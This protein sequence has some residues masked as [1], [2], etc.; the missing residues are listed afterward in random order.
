V[1]AGMRLVS[2]RRRNVV[3]AVAG[4]TPKVAVSDR[5]LSVKPGSGA[6]VAADP[7]LVAPGWTLY[8]L[9]ADE[10]EFWQGDPE[11]RHVRLRYRRGADGWTR[12]L[13]WP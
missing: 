13:L 10:A 12:Q 6:R 2:P 5:I 9:T 3:P 11:R 4:M 7:R 8:A 1:T